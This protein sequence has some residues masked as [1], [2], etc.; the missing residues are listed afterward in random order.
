[1]SFEDITPYVSQ[2]IRASEQHKL[3]LASSSARQASNY[4]V[5]E[6]LYLVVECFLSNKILEHVVFKH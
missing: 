6:T 5:K 1:M 4:K 3:R 2:T